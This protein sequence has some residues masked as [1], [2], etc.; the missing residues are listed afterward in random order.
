LVSRLID[1]NLIQEKNVFHWNLTTLG[2][3]SMKYIYLDLLNEN[4]VYLRKY[5]WKTKVPLKL[6]NFIWFLDR[7]VILRIDNLAK[8][9]W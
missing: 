4:I 3:F 8:R 9:K 1:L 6:R 2:G 5:I 7:K